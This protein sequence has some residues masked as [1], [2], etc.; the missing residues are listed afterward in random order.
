M[1]YVILLSTVFF[2]FGCSSTKYQTTERAFSSNVS[3]M[4]PI[5]AKVELIFNNEDLEKIA[6]ID[7]TKEFAFKPATSL[8]PDGK[9]EG[10]INV[11]FTTLDPSSLLIESGHPILQTQEIQNIYA[12]L[13]NEILTKYP[14][15]DYLIFSKL[16]LSVTS[17][18]KKYGAYSGTLNFRSKAVRVK[19]L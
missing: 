15:T 2:L 7:I 6:D 14:S 16:V 3:S 4:P 11:F 13:M 12:S 19:F 5:V 10:T 8:F 9:A 18:S 1:K 17:D